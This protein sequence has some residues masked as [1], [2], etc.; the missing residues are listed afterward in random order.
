MLQLKE[1]AVSRHVALE[2][3]FY[4][5][6]KIR[7]G[8]WNTGIDQLV[9][10]RIGNLETSMFEIGIKQKDGTIYSLTLVSATKS[11]IKQNSNGNKVIEKFGLPALKIDKWQDDKLH[12]IND[13]RDFKIFIN[14]NSVSFILAPKKIEMKI[15]NDIV[16]FGFD[17]EQSLCMIEINTCDSKVK[18][19]LKENLENK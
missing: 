8:I 13:I 10:W 1:I 11:Q 7:I 12:Y 17:K 18:E 3:D 2:S 5:P 19:N 14:N 6:I 15:I 4:V 9:Y 16:T